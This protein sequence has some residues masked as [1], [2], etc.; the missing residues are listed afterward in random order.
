M[1]TRLKTSVLIALCGSAVLALAACHKEQ[2]GASP[3]DPRPG[4]YKGAPVASLS[5]E[6]LSELDKR[7]KRQEFYNVGGPK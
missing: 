1:A 7:A 3:L 5:P 6:V 4:A 2:P